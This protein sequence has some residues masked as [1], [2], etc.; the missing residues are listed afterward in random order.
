MSDRAY[1][2]DKGVVMVVTEIDDDYDEPLAYRVSKNDEVIGY[3]SY[4][5]MDGWWVFE[6]SGPGYAEATDAARALVEQS[7]PV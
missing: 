5:M 3:I 6:D 4:D 1:Q 7:V 2:L